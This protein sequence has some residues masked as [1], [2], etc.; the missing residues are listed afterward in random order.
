MKSRETMLELKKL[1]VR[2]ERFD[3]NKYKLGDERAM[4]REIFELAN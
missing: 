4:G 3:V 1:I 2:L